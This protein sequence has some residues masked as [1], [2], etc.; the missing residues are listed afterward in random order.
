LPAFRVDTLTG[1]LAH[2]EDTCSVLVFPV[3]ARIRPA[4]TEAIREFGARPLQKWMSAAADP[5]LKQRPLLLSYDEPTQ[6]ISAKF[7]EDWPGDEL[8]RQYY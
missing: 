8:D 4:V 7:A 5:A 1:D 6:R 2:F 3:K